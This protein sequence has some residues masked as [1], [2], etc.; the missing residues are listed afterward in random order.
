M[1]FDASWIP[2]I[3]HLEPTQISMLAAGAPAL[4]SV[5]DGTAWLMSSDGEDIL[6]AVGDCADAVPQCVPVGSTQEVPVSY[7]LAVARKVVH[8]PGIAELGA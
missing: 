1:N 5:A 8:R 3:R 7:G 6:L 4:L 2:C